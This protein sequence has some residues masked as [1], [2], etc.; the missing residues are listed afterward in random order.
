MIRFNVLKN[1]GTLVLGGRLFQIEN[2][3]I[4]ETLVDSTGSH[5]HSFRNE[6]RLPQSFEVADTPEVRLEL[7]PLIEQGVVEIVGGAA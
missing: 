3:A 1:H 6:V 2:T 4:R 5:H 7:E